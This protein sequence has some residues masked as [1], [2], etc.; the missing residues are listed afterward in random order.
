MERIPPLIRL[1][2][3]LYLTYRFEG[4][5]MKHATTLACLCACLLGSTA[6]VSAAA[7]EPPIQAPKPIRSTWAEIRLKGAY[8][9]G[10]QSL[11]LFG[12]STESLS[13][14]VARLDR[15][16]KD[17]DISGVILNIS[18]PKVGWGKLHE[19]RRAIG[20]IR[21]GGKRVY[22]VLDSAS[23]MDY[24]LATSC[25]EIV[26]PESGVVML[27]GLRAEVNFYKN[28]LDWLEI[29]AEMLHVGEFKSAAE[30]YTRTEMSPAFR[31]QM[32][33]ILD[34]YYRQTVDI[35]AKARGLDEHKV[36]AAIDSGPHTAQAALELG[37]ID[38]VAYSDELTGMISRDSAVLDV[39]VSKKYAKRK[40]DTDFSGIGGM[41]KVM[42]A[43][44]GLDSKPR[45][46]L[47][48]KI[49]VIH[50]TGTINTGR[51]TSSLFGGSML[52]SETLI[53]AIRQAAGDSTVKAVVLR[54]DS[55]GGSAL[56]S[57][58]IWRAL[59]KLDKPFVA[60]MGDTAAS[61][62][63]YI[64]MGAHTIFAEPGTLTG[65]I[66][67]V[68]GK[69]ALKGLFEKV[70]ITTS[71]IS[72][73]QNSGIMSIMDGFTDTERKA[74]QRMLH[75]VYDQ[76]THKAAAGRG[77][78]H[79]QLE[80]LARGRVYTGAMALEIGLVDKL[81]TLEDAIAHA[82][83]L[84]DLE[85]EK[86]VER[87]ILPR[88]VGPLEML[89]GP[90]GADAQANTRT[91]RALVGALESLSPEL[92]NQFQAAEMIRL[93]SSESRLTIMPFRLVVR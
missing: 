1:L 72:R 20:R 83:K 2:V 3:A 34:D 32:E 65:S 81:G 77:M 87:L 61:G 68:G 93:L 66:G 69:I 71:V 92:A 75:E 62:G 45:R 33:A 15:A 17:E 11:S 78:E 82:T 35:V 57:D 85:S 64:S 39:R 27:L 43:L 25:D 41:M 16:A 23:S 7:P 91:S 55:P 84:A 88:P 31:K 36:E 58:L 63:Y 56:A 37:L 54:V 90:M 24:L 80:K 46:S 9:E 47:Y 79:E 51:S 73:G 74:M 89:L 48:P 18:S 76:F 40:R 38:R 6:V 30:P 59:E 29:K 67:V 21:A 44:M 13:A 14:G 12:A 50:A 49:A 70:G 22:A 4:F 19:M 52:G 60:S 26:M 86:K 8:P 28:L 10:A 53:K 42:N 5:L